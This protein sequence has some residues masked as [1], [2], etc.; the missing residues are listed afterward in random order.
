[1]EGRQEFSPGFYNGLT[2]IDIRMGP[3]AERFGNPSGV[4]KMTYQEIRYWHSWC[5]AYHDA[6]QKK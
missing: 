2:R 4:S 6:E 3:I 5:K 1:M